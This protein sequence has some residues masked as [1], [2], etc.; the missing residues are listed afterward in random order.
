M[1]HHHRLR[2]L[3]LLLATR[4]DELHDLAEQSGCVQQDARPH[5]NSPTAEDSKSIG[6]RLRILDLTEMY[7]LH[8]LI[9][10]E[11]G[12]K[13]S[14]LYMLTHDELSQLLRKVHLA[15]ECII[16]GISFDDAGLISTS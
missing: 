15:R 9:R 8:W 10:Q 3:A 4:V 6:L 7:S 1:Q 14:A 2:E 11:V 16:E 12:P 13:K 5:R